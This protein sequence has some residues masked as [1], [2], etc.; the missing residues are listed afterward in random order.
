MQATPPQPAQNINHHIQQ[1]Q[2]QQ[3]QQPQQ[4]PQQPKQNGQVAIHPQGQMLQ[5][6]GPYP[7]PPNIT[8]DQIQAMVQV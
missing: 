6:P 5:G 2:L 4:Q 7:L 1:Q 3:Q 8:R